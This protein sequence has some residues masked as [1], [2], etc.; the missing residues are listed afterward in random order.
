[1]SIEKSV[2]I[3]TSSGFKHISLLHTSEGILN[4]D[5]LNKTIKYNYPTQILNYRSMFFFHV[6]S[7]QWIPKLLLNE[8]V[9]LIPFPVQM[10]INY[11]SDILEILNPYLNQYSIGLV[12]ETFEN[13]PFDDAN[14]IQE[15]SCKSGLFCTIQLTDL[16]KQLY[17][18]EFPD[19]DL[20]STKFMRVDVT[21]NVDS[22]AISTG[23][24]NSVYICRKFTDSFVYVP[25]FVKN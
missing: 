12:G 15:L 18:V 19:K 23:D 11:E 16:V 10:N 17:C 8:N 22:V 25:F 13:I 20:I 5:M 9:Q 1:M 4:V 14:K 6:Y 21:S 2:E 24:C 3:L 7:N